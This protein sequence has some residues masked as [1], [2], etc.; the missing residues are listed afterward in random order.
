[1]ELTFSPSALPPDFTT[2]TE[3]QFKIAISDENLT[4]LKK[5]LE[6]VRFSDE[7]E[8]AGR[9]YGASL[10]EFQRLVVYWKDGFDCRKHE[11]QWNEEM[12]QFN[13]HRGRRLWVVECSLQ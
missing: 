3:G 10:K 11:A 2:T 5:K 9:D 7:L 1:M 4:I 6:L 13:I 12:I 8:K